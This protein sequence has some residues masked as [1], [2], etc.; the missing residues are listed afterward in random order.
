MEPK[1]P[2][3]MMHTLIRVRRYQERMALPIKRTV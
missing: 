3:F 1:E 2:D